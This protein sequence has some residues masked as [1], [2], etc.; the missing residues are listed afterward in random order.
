MGRIEFVSSVSDISPWRIWLV[1]FLSFLFLIYFLRKNKLSFFSILLIALSFEGVFEYIELNKVYNIILYVIILIYLIYN[2]KREGLS[3]IFIY[4]LILLFVFLLT[5]I[6]HGSIGLNSYT[7]QFI[8]FSFPII[9]YIILYQNRGRINYINELDICIKILN[10]QIVAGVLKLILIGFNEK[11][12]GTISISGGSIPVLIP[13]FYFV[14]IYIM[15]NGKLN[16]KNWGMILLSLIIPIS[17]NKRAVW[18]VLPLIMLLAFYLYGK[19]RFKFRTIFL[20]TLIPFIFY[21]GV[22]FNPTLNPEGI[23]WGS[24]DYGYVKEYVF[25]YNLGTRNTSNI[26][27]TNSYKPA[28]RMGNNL[29]YFKK[30]INAPFSTETLFGI[31]NQLYNETE[32]R[33]GGLGFF[34]KFMLTAWVEILVRFGSLVL[35]IYVI[36]IIKMLRNIRI[37]KK[38]YK[39]ILF[40]FFTFFI[41]YTS[42]I[43]KTSFFLSLLLILVFSIKYS[44]INSSNINYNSSNLIDTKS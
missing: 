44:S 28:G 4:Y 30:I 21:F 26:L 24:F 32:A 43:T 41:F 16:L 23:I 12:S 2:I 33:G 35:L 17:S 15:N 38:E 10:V 9:L 18:F 27:E 13:I 3:K 40:L 22:R 6:F 1:F 14:L 34:S 7:G 25:D 11:M 8:S 42:A 36:V 5:F 39:L 31:G 37:H 19:L 29:V 20:L